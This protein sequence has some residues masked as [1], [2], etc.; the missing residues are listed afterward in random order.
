MWDNL[1]RN[2]QANALTGPAGDVT[3]AELIEAAA[4]WGNAFKGK[5][6]EQG[7]RIALFLDDTPAYPAAFFGAVRAG[8]VPVLL[9]TM[10]PVD[11]LAYYL[12]DSDA[13][14]I[15]ADKAFESLFGEMELKVPLVIVGGDA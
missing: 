15:V 3:Y 6:L 9:N 11:V 12:T 1:N 8:F 4:K 14:L 10:T 13:R 5:G 7:D 2:P